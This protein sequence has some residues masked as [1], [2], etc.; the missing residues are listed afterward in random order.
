MKNVTTRFV[1]RK[2][3]IH[4][5]KTGQTS[6]YLT[7]SYNNSRKRFVLPLLV[8][9]ANW[10]NAKQRITKN[11]YDYWEKN[12]LLAFY[13]VQVKTYISDCQIKKKPFTFDGLKAMVFGNAVS[14]CYFEFV[15]T[16]TE[17]DATLSHE[18]KRTYLAKLNKLSRF[19]NK[20]S[21]SEIDYNFLMEYKNWMILCGNEVNTYSK[22]LSI[23][24]SFL[25]RAIQKGL[26]EK[27]DFDKVKIKWTDGKRDFLDMAELQTLRKLYTGNLDDGMKSHL[28]K[29]FEKKELG[30]KQKKIVRKLLDTGK[31]DCRLKKVLHL[32]LFTCY[33]GLRYRDLKAF[34]HEHIKNNFIVLKMHKTQK[35]VEIP[36]IH[37]A[38][39]LLPRECEPYDKQPIFDVYCNQI[40]NR[41]I[42]EIS[43]IAGI[44]KTIT[45]HVARHTFATLAFDSGM[46]LEEVS[47]ILGHSDMKTTLIYTKILQQRKVESM[48][49]FNQTI[50]NPVE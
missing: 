37:E 4:A 34:R 6:I 36:L 39:K 29:L 2:D 44:N 17:N 10:D 45:L 46:K 5:A 24:K 16:E 26:I 25:N 50:A 32:F 13:E 47:K 20:L 43:V 19:R 3:Y 31:L 42:K 28:Q 22:D 15:K 9:P 21:I 8:T 38:I 27:H 40:L 12:K 41:Y 49:V 18:T 23:I 35:D 30:Y 7:A 48:N 14:D 1:I 33:T 11:E